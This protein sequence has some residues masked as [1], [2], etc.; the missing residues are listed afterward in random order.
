MTHIFPLLHQIDAV[1]EKRRRS[2]ESWER[3]AMC[4]ATTVHSFVHVIPYHRQINQMDVRADRVKAWP[5]KRGTV[6]KQREWIFLG[7]L[8]KANG[9]MKSSA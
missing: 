2:K 5:R 9:W 7:E 1:K 6:C 8:M 3:F 4:D